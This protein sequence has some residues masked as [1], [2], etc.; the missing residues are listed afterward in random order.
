MNACPI[1]GLV[2]GF[3]GSIIPGCT[4]ITNLP[5]TY[6]QQ[7]QKE[8]VGLTDDEKQVCYWFE[9]PAGADPSLFAERIEKRLKEKNT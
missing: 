6:H 2:K 9:C 7:T 8:W 5:N 1:C 4:C 3:H